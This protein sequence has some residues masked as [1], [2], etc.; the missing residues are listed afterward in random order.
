MTPKERLHLLVDKLADEQ[1]ERVLA[2]LESVAA[3][4]A[5]PSG[6]RVLP[7]SLG[8]GDSGRSDVSERV[9]EVL[10]EGFGR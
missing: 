2:L 8:F 4:G 10:A 1:A 3:A 5:A 9:D 6:V 7:K